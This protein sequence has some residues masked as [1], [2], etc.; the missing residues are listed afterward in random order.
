MA[1]GNAFISYLGLIPDPYHKRETCE[2]G[3]RM[4]AIKADKKVFCDVGDVFTNNDRFPRRQSPTIIGVRFC[5][6]LLS[7]ELALELF[8][9]LMYLVGTLVA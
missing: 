4:S 6:T 1:I 2:P 5:D 9:D 3:S 7:F 8:S